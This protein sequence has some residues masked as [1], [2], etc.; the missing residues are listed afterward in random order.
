MASYTQPIRERD[1]VKKQYDLLLLTV[2]IIG[3]RLHLALSFEENHVGLL[4]LHAHHLPV[5]SVDANA[6]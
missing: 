1:H 3:E 6:S 4:G 2:N 5:A